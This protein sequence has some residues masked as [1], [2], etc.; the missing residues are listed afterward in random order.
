[1]DGTMVKGKVGKDLDVDEANAAAEW[2]ALNLL[3][4]MRGE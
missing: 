4:T 1:M 2:V 3:S